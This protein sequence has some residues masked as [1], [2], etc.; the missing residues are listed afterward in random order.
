VSRG[1]VYDPGIGKFVPDSLADP[2]VT[3]SELR[4]AI[5]AGDAVTYTGVPPG[6]G[7]RAG[8][9]R[10]RDGFL[11]RTELAIG[12]DPADPHSNPWR[13]Q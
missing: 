11:D 10:D 13:W 4:A 2:M 8:I 3:E 12:T 5:G 7:V 6:A 9:D 1:W